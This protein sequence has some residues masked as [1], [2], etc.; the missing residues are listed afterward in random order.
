M[1]LVDKFP[2]GFFSDKVMCLPVEK[3][4]QK[5]FHFEIKHLK[6]SQRGS[7]DLGGFN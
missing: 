3:C 6:K 1:Y 5:C 7:N 4:I 2:F